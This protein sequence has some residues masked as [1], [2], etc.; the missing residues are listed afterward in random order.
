VTK[1][2]KLLPVFRFR[3]PPTERRLHNRAMLYWQALK[4]DGEFVLLR[5]FDPMVLEDRSTHGFLL[6][7]MTAEKPVLRFIGP[8]LRDEALVQG[9]D[10]PIA[11]V[12][13]DTLLRRFADR[14]EEVLAARTAIPAE[15]NFVT[16]ADYHVQCRGVLLP[17]SSDG[18]LLDHV[19][20]VISWKS[21]KVRR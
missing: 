4:R 6:D 3:K 21:E 1:F 19:Y 16:S 12:A 2:M 17:L 11:D 14:H 5:D 15:Y 20:G 7:L 10:V 18:V 13:R 8:V 9:N